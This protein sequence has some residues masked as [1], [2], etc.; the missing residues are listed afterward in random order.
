VRAA[1]GNGPGEA[2]EAV[3]TN[4]TTMPNTTEAV[5]AV[6]IEPDA[7]PYASPC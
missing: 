4:T 2:E 5:A 7:A 3:C 6:A 1:A